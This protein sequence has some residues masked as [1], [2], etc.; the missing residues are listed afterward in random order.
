[1]ARYMLVLRGGNDMWASYTPEQA[2]AMMQKYADWTEEIR[3]KGVMVAGDPLETGGR[4][5]SVRNGEVVDGPYTETKEDIAGYYIIQA[6]DYDKAVEIS[7]G[8][9]TLLHGGDVEIRA[10]QEM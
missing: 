3:K 6:D 8:C 5:L 4:V 7:K 10:I 9:P 1:M 2:Q